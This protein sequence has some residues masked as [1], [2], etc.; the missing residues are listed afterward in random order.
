MTPEHII[1]EWY[2]LSFYAI[3]RSIPN[4]VMGVNVIL[5]LFLILT[6]LPF[7][8]ISRRDKFLYFINILTAL[9]ISLIILISF[10]GA[11]IVSEP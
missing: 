4:K 2:F 5:F 6:F 11:S 1:P 3:L 9:F 10:L 7:T 8:M